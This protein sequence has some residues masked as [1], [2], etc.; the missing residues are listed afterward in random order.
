MS[1]AITNTVIAVVAGTRLCLLEL[2][3]LPESVPNVSL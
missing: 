3:P 1:I 2:P